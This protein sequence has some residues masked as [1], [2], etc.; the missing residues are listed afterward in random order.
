MSDSPSSA[1]PCKHH[2]VERLPLAEQTTEVVCL[3]CHARV[4]CTH[5]WVARYHTPTFLEPGDEVT[6]CSWCGSKLWPS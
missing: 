4:P 1:K 2:S 6:H 5:P 3:N